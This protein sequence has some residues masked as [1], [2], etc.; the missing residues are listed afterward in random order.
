MDYVC[1]ECMNVAYDNGI[2]DPEKQVLVMVT[3]GKECEDHICERKELTKE[4]L[5]GRICKC[6]CNR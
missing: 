3:S 5:E 6:S 1:D 2:D 4:E